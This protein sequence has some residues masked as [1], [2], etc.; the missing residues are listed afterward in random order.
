MA[1]AHDIPIPSFPPGAS[2]PAK[3]Q[4]VFKAIQSHPRGGTEPRMRLLLI[5]E[6]QTEPLRQIEIVRS[7]SAP[8]KVAKLLGC[9]L[10]DYETLYSQDQAA[11]VRILSLIYISYR[12]PC[13]FIN[14]KL[15]THTA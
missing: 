12:L 4:L 6:S 2:D 15:A 13:A 5:P 7:P 3:A 9:Q 8:G 10:T 14:R 1:R 11:I